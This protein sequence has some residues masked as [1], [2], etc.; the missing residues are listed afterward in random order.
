MQTLTDLKERTKWSIDFVL[1]QRNLKSTEMSKTLGVKPDTIRKYRSRMATPRVSFLQ[2]FCTAFEIDFQWLTAGIG[3]PF[4]DKNN[5]CNHTPDIREQLKQPPETRLHNDE[6][7]EEC[8]AATPPTDRYPKNICADSEM[9]FQKLAVLLGIKIDNEWIV[10]LSAIIGV[11]PWKISLSIYH[12]QIDKELIR[13][14]ENCGYERHKWVVRRTWKKAE[15]ETD[16]DELNISRL[17][18]MAEEVLRSNSIHAT[19]LAMNIISLKSV[20]DNDA[21]S[22]VSG[23]RAISLP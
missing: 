2:K 19:S 7:P 17:C 4:P 18:K 11:A 1:E 3:T 8:Q 6:K 14:V 5:S 16:C 13:A 21:S 9:S 22:P 23:A 12:Q 10:K 20:Y 15:P